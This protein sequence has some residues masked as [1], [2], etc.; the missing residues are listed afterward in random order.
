M[1]EGGCDCSDGLGWRRAEGVRT[2]QCWAMRAARGATALKYEGQQVSST[3]WVSSTRHATH[4]QLPLQRPAVPLQLPW[5]LHSLRARPVGGGAQCPQDEGHDVARSHHAGALPRVNGPLVQ[6][7]HALRRHCGKGGCGV[8][9]WGVGGGNMS[10][11]EGKDLPCQR[12]TRRPNRNGPKPPSAPSGQAYEGVG[13]GGGEKDHSMHPESGHPRVP[14][15]APLGRCRKQR[16]TGRASR[17][18]AP[19]AP[20]RTQRRSAAGGPAPGLPPLPLLCSGRAAG[21]RRSPGARGRRGCR[22]CGGRCRW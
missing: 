10:N 19:A 12:P 6:N 20:A 1:A 4:L 13:L 3:R 7:R 15:R 2:D 9:A 16:R 14:A 11:G 5:P 17:R 22:G 8:C 18:P 21:C